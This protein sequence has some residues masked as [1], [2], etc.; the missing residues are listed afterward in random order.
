MPS[1]IPA[2][3]R[4]VECGSWA[5]RAV[6]AELLTPHAG[7]PKDTASFAPSPSLHPSPPQTR[8]LHHGQPDP[9]H[10]SPPG[11]QP[12][13]AGP[14]GAAQSSARLPCLP[15]GTGVGKKHR[16][17]PEAD[18]FGHR[19]Q[20]PSHSVVPIRYLTYPW[21]PLPFPPV[22]P[23]RSCRGKQGL[24]SVADARRAEATLPAPLV[25]GTPE[26]GTK[27]PGH[28]RTI[29]LQ[30]PWQSC[31]PLCFVTN[32]RLLHSRNHAIM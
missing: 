3:R 9:S 21:Q 16:T 17:G 27:Q 30:L 26:G 28:A 11:G 6:Q 20:T 2:C 12:S 8:P 10:I 18:S 13:L 7:Q 32:L 22:L 14:P 1:N 4:P 19:G 24:L 31:Q 25:S 23:G 5:G 29:A 15:A